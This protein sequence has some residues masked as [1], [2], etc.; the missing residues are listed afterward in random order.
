VPAGAHAR[1]VVQRRD[2]PARHRDA[3]VGAD[4]ARATGAG[5]D[6]AARTPRSHRVEQVLHVPGRADGPRS[7]VACT[8]APSIPVRPV[9]GAV[10]GVAVAGTTGVAAAAGEARRPAPAPRYCG[11]RRSCTPPTP[12]A[13]RA[14]LR[15]R[16]P[17]VRERV[18]HVAGE[19]QGRGSATGRDVIAPGRVVRVGLPP[20]SASAIAAMMFATTGRRPPAPTALELALAQ[21][22]A[23]G[24]SPNLPALRHV[25]RARDRWNSRSRPPIGASARSRTGNWRPDGKWSRPG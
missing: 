14:V 19:R 24:C 5:T 2:H 10:I 21:M 23:A 25:V 13:L 7:S 18:V 3:L 4:A 17:G 8:I 11:T 6:R 9:R 1:C 16:H 12:R 20:D 22:L 15:D